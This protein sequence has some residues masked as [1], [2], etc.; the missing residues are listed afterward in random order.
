MFNKTRNRVIANN[1]VKKK[2]MNKLFV[3][4]RYWC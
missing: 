4:Y 3:Y 2:Y 1:N